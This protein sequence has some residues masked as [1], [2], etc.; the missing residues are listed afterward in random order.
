MKKSVFR[1]IFMKKTVFK[2]HI[3]KLS[4]S[5]I[6][7]I[8]YLSDTGLSEGYKIVVEIYWK[9]PTATENIALWEEKFLKFL[10]RH[11]LGLTQ[12]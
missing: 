10:I 12:R 9:K 4:Q 2:T 11:P 7:Q 1:D 6:F 3:L 8:W 5:F